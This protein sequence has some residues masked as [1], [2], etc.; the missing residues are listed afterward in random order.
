MMAAQLALLGAGLGLVVAPTTAAVVDAAPA[1]RR[2][3]AAGLVIV[4]RLIGLSVG[5]SGLTAWALFRFN[6][7]RDTLEL[8]PL[9]SDGYA[10][11]LREAQTELTTSALAETFL[12]AAVV[13]A[14][15]VAVAMLMRRDSPPNADPADPSAE[16][17]AVAV[18][19]TVST[20][21][22]SDPAVTEE[23]STD[24][25]EFL[26]RP[27]PWLRLAVLVT[28]AVLVVAVAF[29]AVRVV[30][31]GGEVDALQED[32]TRV[33][34]GA[35]VYAAQLTAFQQQIADLAPTVGGALDEAIVGLEEFRTS[36]LTFEIPIDQV[37]PI[38][39]DIEIDRTISV[40]VLTEL[41]I[42]ETIDTTITVAG[43]F[44]I[45]I[46]VDVSVPV[47]VVVPI[48]LDLEFP[49]DE[50]IPIQTEIP[51]NLTVPIEI[52]VAETEL[53]TLA[54]SLQLGLEGF[55]D[56]ISGLGG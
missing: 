22:P 53:A 8:P 2:G 7:L 27:Q 30:S 42:N 24:M 1:E 47:A 52:P 23:A 14:V 3:T 32:L 13:T 17:D 5:L 19:I 9:G 46:P 55:A 44:G 49:I 10:E 38:D 48:D 18:P 37:I 12:A 33:E 31:L 56:V 51:V 40:P 4:V 36:T 21:H 26:S 34:G 50:T 20:D 15:G 25:K 39:L 45:D 28:V 41:P 11:A 16:S 6:Q 35:A 43:P 29:L 54:E